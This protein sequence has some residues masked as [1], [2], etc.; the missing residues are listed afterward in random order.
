MKLEPDKYYTVSSIMRYGYFPWV[1][2]PMT[3]HKILK[4]KGPLYKTLNPIERTTSKGHSYLIKGEKIQNVIK[5][6]EE[7][8][9]KI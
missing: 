3:L 9:L 5:L 6:I 2:S 7:G 4:E 8:K 1:R